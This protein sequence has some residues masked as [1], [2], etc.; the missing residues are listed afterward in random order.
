[1][2]RR[3]DEIPAIDRRTEQQWQQIERHIHSVR[4]KTPVVLLITAAPKSPPQTLALIIL[5]A[6]LLAIWEGARREVVRFAQDATASIFDSLRAR[7]H[8]PERPQNATTGGTPDSDAA[9][10]R[11]AARAGGDTAPPPDK[12]MTSTR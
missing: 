7:L 10:G 9:Q 8:I 2:A 6:I 12:R 1:M 3:E 4:A 5:L 11:R